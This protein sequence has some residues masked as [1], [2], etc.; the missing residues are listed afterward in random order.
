MTCFFNIKT[1]LIK[2]MWTKRSTCCKPDE[3]P[4]ERPKYNSKGIFVL[5]QVTSGNV[6]R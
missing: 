4:E 5:K 1:Q 3:I 2:S 6:R